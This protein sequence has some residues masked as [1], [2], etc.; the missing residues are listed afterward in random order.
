MIDLNTAYNNA[1]VKQQEAEA[2]AITDAIAREQA[3]QQQLIRQQQLKDTYNS[4]LIENFENIKSFLGDRFIVTM[5]D[6][7]YGGYYGYKQILIK[8][9]NIELWQSNYFGYCQIKNNIKKW[10]TLDEL[11]TQIN[12]NLSDYIIDKKL[13]GLK[14]CF[15]TYF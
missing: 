2:K 8:Y 11:K 1:V 15:G 13:H 3:Y 7:S 4:T 14:T 12:S 6:D 10:T 9:P 5:S